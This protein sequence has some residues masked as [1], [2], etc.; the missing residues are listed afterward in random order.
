MNKKIERTYSKSLKEYG[1]NDPRSI[2]WGDRKTQEYRFKILLELRAP[3]LNTSSVVDLGCGLGDLY[4]YLKKRGFKGKYVGIDATPSMIRAAKKRYPVQFKLGSSSVLAD[5]C[6][7]SGTF[8]DRLGGTQAQQKKL[9]FS[10]IADAFKKTKKA[11]SFNLISNLCFR[12]SAQFISGWES[13]F[14]FRF[15]GIDTVKVGI[16]FVY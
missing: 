11:V 2:H 4:G 12:Y 3:D 10:T 7:I 1:P 6:F 13:I 5:Y 8:N 9:V 16:L 15:S 14:F